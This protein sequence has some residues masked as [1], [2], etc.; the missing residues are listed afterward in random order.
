MRGISARSAKILVGITVMGLLLGVPVYATTTADLVIGTVKGLPGG[1]VSVPVSVIAHG[2]E[3]GAVTLT[4]SYNPTYLTYVP[5]VTEGA[6]TTAAGKQVLAT[7]VSNGELSLAVFGVTADALQDGV[8]LS[9]KFTISQSM[10]NASTAITGS[11]GSIASTD[12]INI[13]VNTVNGAIELLCDNVGISQT[14]TATQDRTDG[15][16]VQWAPAAA[17]TAYRVYRS[18]LQDPATAIVIADWT[19][20]FEYLDESAV[21]TSTGTGCNAATGT[22]TTYYYWVQPRKDANC[23]GEFTGPAAG[24]VGTAKASAAM[25]GDWLVLLCAAGLLIF[26]RQRTRPGIS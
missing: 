22:P 26:R 7:L 15:V 10:P 2:T 21:T 8:L 23:L 25:P 24:T 12:G 6:S 1:Q 16:L 4:L 17:A 20:G 11:E 19:T 5:P 18:T 3:P 14:V 9:V 13:P